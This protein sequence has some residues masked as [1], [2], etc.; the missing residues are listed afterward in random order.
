A[1]WI[2][3]GVIRLAVSW[4]RPVRQ[5]PGETVSVDLANTRHIEAPVSHADLGPQPFPALG[6]VRLR[7]LGPELLEETVDAPGFLQATC[8]KLR[9]DV[10]RGDP[11]PPHWG[12]L[13]TLCGCPLAIDRRLAAAEH[14]LAAEGRS[15]PTMDLLG[16]RGHGQSSSRSRARWASSPT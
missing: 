9:K 14:A 3:A 11:L 10:P 7:Y 5:L 13:S 4:H 8:A 2:V 16:R 1:P 12:R 6:Q 15:L